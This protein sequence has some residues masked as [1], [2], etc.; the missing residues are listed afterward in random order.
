MAK[1]KLVWTNATQMQRNLDAYR[2]K[3]KY[4]IRQ[5]ANYWQPVIEAYAKE[6]ATWIDRTSNARQSLHSF[7]DE[8][9]NDTVALYLAHGRPYGI[10]LEVKG[11]HPE[12]ANAGKYAIILP[13]LEAHY[14]PIRK[15]LKEIFS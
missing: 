14:E 4:A 9:A 1:A 12:V 2:D 10:W 11:E 15:M 8:L 13:T 6:N 5:V 3:A 7:V